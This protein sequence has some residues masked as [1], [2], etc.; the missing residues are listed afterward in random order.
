MLDIQAFPYWG[1]IA[2]YNG[3]GYLAELGYDYH[4]ALTVVADLHSHTWVDT[5][6]RAIFVEFTVY[7]ANTNLFG[8]AFIF[9][10]FLPTGGAYPNAQFIISRFYNYV[11]SYSNFIICCQIL[12]V[13][14]VVYFS[15][16]EIKQVYKQG[17]GYFHGFWNWMEVAMI[18]C[19]FSIFVLFFGRMYQ[20]S[21][22]LSELRYNPKDFVSFQ[23]ASAADDSLAYSIGMLVFFVNI[24]F[25]KLLR[26]NKR[27]ALLGDTI[28]IMAKPVASFMLCFAVVVIAFT[29]V[30]V[31]VFGSDNPEYYSFLAAL[32]T[33]FR[34]LL[35][36]F[37]YGT[38]EKT[39][40]IIGPIYFFSFMYFN[41]FYLMNMFLAIINDTFAEVK[42]DNDK[43]KSEH[44]I[45]EFIIENFKKRIG[46]E[47]AKRQV[48]SYFS[49][50]NIITVIICKIYLV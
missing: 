1:K 50:L 37:E 2:M 35:G 8:V 32:T 36:D 14:F 5:Q 29:C 48:C 30:G 25:L 26:F 47:R 12:F 38:L 45:V 28:S 13:F 17:R 6:T 19:E 27:M 22:N 10:E 46:F 23:Y 42:S 20:V 21:K 40:R 4:T 33:N 18:A 49:S 11:G 34:V 39:N 44:E 31:L 9:I 16:R 7:N 24:R 3:G 43:Q 41:V 15:Y